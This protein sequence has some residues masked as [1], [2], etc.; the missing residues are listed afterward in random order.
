[1]RL[2]PA[3]LVLF[4]SAGFATEPKPLSL[5]DEMRLFRERERAL[6]WKDG[7]SE[8]VAIAR[9][10]DIVRIDGTN[11]RS[12]SLRDRLLFGYPDVVVGRFCEQFPSE[13]PVDVARSMVDRLA[14]NAE[15]SPKV[16]EGIQIY[17]ESYRLD[18]LSDDYR[19]LAE[20][21]LG[22]CDDADRR[23][24]ARKILCARR[25]RHA[26]GLADAAGPREFDPK[27]EEWAAVPDRC[28]DKLAPTVSCDFPAN[29]DVATMFECRTDDD[30]VAIKSGCGLR[31]IVGD[32]PNVHHRHRCRCARGAVVRGCFPAETPAPSRGTEN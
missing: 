15:I 9:L 11:A 26:K 1:M 19:A 6:Q 28:R 29:D 24:D 16:H 4:A 17:L 30:C 31:A 3:L 2:L 22:G 21:H 8:T 27:P 14:A 12:R 20:R 7:T 32:S 10:G 18:R 5:G 25:V 23:V 13:T